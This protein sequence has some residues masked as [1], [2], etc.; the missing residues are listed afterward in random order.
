MKNSYLDVRDELSSLL[1]DMDGVISVG[2]TKKADAICLLVAVDPDQYS[3]GVPESFQGIDVVV[4]DLGTP[5][6]FVL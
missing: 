3:G 2:I 6:V 5:E 4:R 1:A